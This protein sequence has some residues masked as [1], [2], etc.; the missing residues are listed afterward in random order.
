MRNAE[1]RVKE[2]ERLM[3]EQAKAFAMQLED[4]KKK[5]AKEID[6][7][8][9][10]H[11]IERHKDALKY[12]RLERK[13]AKLQ[14]KFNN[15]VAKKE[16]EKEIVKVYNH[17][18]YYGTKENSAYINEKSPVNE[19]E[20]NLNKKKK[21]RPKGSKNYAKWDFEKLATTTVNN[22]I[23]QELIQKGYKFAK[24]GEDISYLIRVRKEIEVV[25][26]ITPKYVR[27]D[28]KD[29]RI[30]QA[31]SNSIFPHSVCTASFVADVIAAKY[32]LN[33]PIERYAKYLN[34]K[35]LYFSA[36]DLTN[37]VK[38][39]D[40]LMQPL[41]NKIKNSLVNDSVH[42]I[43]V[44]ETPIEVLD[45]LKRQGDDHRKNGYIFVYVT[46]YYDYPIYLYD[47]SETR[48][49]EK[50]Q[51]LL[52]NY[53]KFV[54]ADGYSGYDILK[55]RGIK[56]QL[57][58]AHIR[59]KFY[60]IAKTLNKNARKES[61]AVEMVNKID[62][63]FHEEALMKKNNL[64]PMEIY[65][66]RQSPE[67]MAIVNDI[68]DYLETII[69]ES[70]SKLEDAVNYFKNGL[71]DSKTFL[72]DGH[73]PISNNI[74]ERAIRPFTILRGN[75]L[76]VKNES[77]AGI[78]ARL[79]TIIQSARANGLKVEDYLTYVMENIG[80]VEV[81]ELLPWS[82]TLPDNLKAF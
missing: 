34:S 60:D 33:V 38:R 31:L 50:T 36:M 78:S 68:Y 10:Q 57:C 64:S 20:V 19:V 21:G 26:V 46:T 73:I 74:A 62:K 56:L 1:E 67:Y 80:K 30:Y 37:Y 4:E 24:I 2:L 79:F 44:D 27:K 81:V 70:G 82:K 11:Q 54:V 40:A 71:E 45:Y 51:E 53:H 16:K 77:G 29:G 61:S 23:A 75:M 7:I 41:Y 35:G 48:E 6:E 66:H 43:N 63:L 12:S 17:N 55:E 14:E 65:E 3:E 47:F 5:H 58:F 18:K 9:K 15:E 49:T 13:F 8:K 76:F 72:L 69:P 25:K 32:Y 52:K 22:D 39:A 59:R 28:V 42:V